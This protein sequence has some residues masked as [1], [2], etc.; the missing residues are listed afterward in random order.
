[1][2]LESFLRRQP[3]RCRSCGY[4]VAEQGCRC[5]GSEWQ[6]FLMAL[7]QSVRADGTVHASDV[8][9]LVRK[10]IK[11]QHI[12]PMYARAHKEGLISD[13]GVY[14]MSDDL[15]GRNAHKPERVWVWEAA[16]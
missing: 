15:I 12:G 10:K 8:R 4:A 16:A 14:E 9:P 6:L 13:S 2:S 1:M 3:G 7:R 11:A 5:L